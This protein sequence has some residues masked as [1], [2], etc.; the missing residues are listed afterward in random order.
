MSTARQDV[1]DRIRKSNAAIPAAARESEYETIQRQY[2]Q[3]GSSERA[4]ILDCFVDRLL[5]YGCGVHRCPEAELPATI[6][7]MLQARGLSGILVA[8][9]VPPA[10]RPEQINFVEDRNFTY[11]ELDASPGVL[12][13][14][15]AAIALTGSIILSHRGTRRALTLIPDYHLCVVF[16]SQVVETVPEA[17]R[18]LAALGNAPVTTIAG[19]SATADI[20]MT[21]I[22]GV[23]GPRFLDVILAASQH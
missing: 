6:S 7:A 3:S 14:C 22:Q 18:Q 8:T 13:T 2:R 4:A 12:T 11:E 21:R 15:A 5:D 20:E 10:W 1:L 9:G 16:E 19:P 17:I 23:H